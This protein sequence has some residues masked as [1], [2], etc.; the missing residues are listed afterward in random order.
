MI[1][2][3]M[4]DNLIRGMDTGRAKTLYLREGQVFQGRISELYPGQLARLQMGT[5][6][7]SARL[8]ARLEKGEKYWF[9]VISGERVPQLK[10]LEN[11]S[12]N[13]PGSS[14]ASVTNVPGMLKQLGLPTDGLHKKIIRELIR[15]NLPFTRSNILQGAQLVKES[16][17]ASNDSL[18]LIT[19]MIQRGYP[20]TRAAFK[21]L[22]SVQS[23]K[24]TGETMVQLASTLEKLPDSRAQHLQHI[25]ANISGRFSGF[26]EGDIFVIFKHLTGKD[27]ELQ[28]AAIKVLKETGLINS[29]D[30]SIRFFTSFKETVLNPANE[31]M[32]GKLWPGLFKSR[33][34]ALPLK[35]MDPKL[36]FSYLTDSLRGA[37]LHSVTQLLTLINPQASA[38]SI[39]TR[40]S[41][42]LASE[43]EDS[44]KGIWQLIRDNHSGNGKLLNEGQ[45]QHPLK[46][47]LNQLG[48]Q[49]ENN[50]RSGQLNQEELNTLKAKLIQFLNQSHGLP[51][52]TREQADFLLQRL[53]AYQLLS[54][55]QQGPVQHTVFQIPVKLSE[56]YTDLTLQ[57]QGRE[58]NDGTVDESHCRILFYLELETLRHTLIDVQIQNRIMA[59]TVYNESSKPASIQSVWFPLLKEKLASYNYQLSV[60]KWE[61]AKEKEGNRSTPAMHVNS[62]E[63]GYNGV[64]IK[65]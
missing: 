46:A 51:Q 64:D 16:A 40:L 23:E 12:V 24:S 17:L 18:K 20:L 33:Q 22:A 3:A 53:T 43:P 25:L 7:L 41:Q 10:V 29:L 1:A 19:M 32:S 38:S 65:I 55:E 61:K 56:K 15:V 60:I 5:M 58:K 21:A 9:K 26:G 54:S 2:A 34:T 42:W 14:P 31:N 39:V 44:T 48:L 37:P 57:W 52:G 35:N 27:E 47:F 8:E 49:H 11:V 30:S 63:Y 62:F 28:E 59:L 13:R 50:I 6:N 36:L 4:L 45:T